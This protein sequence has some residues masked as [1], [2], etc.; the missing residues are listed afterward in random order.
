[1]DDR[2]KQLQERFKLI[3][4]AIGEKY[5]ENTAFA[6]ASAAWLQG[7]QYAA[8]QALTKV[9]R[10]AG[11]DVD[12]LIRDL[13]DELEAM[14]MSYHDDLCKFLEVEQDQIIK[15]ATSFREVLHDIFEQGEKK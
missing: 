12:R 1:M 9:K 10:G 4:S 3:E 13:E 5:G 7:I 14:L 15:M 8:L 2:T 6:A 11:G